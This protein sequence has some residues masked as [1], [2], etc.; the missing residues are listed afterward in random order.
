MFLLSIPF[1]EMGK[2]LYKHI[3]SFF[4]SDIMS[5]PIKRHST[6]L[7]LQVTLYTDKE[8]QKK[9]REIWLLYQFPWFY[10]MWWKKQTKN[11]EVYQMWLHK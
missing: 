7:Q 11:K 6:L 5:I 3:N 2:V 9:L 8:Q 10:N 1:C 4:L